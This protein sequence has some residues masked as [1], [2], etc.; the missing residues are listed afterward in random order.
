M[1]EGRNSD[2][3]H[4]LVLL[5]GSWGRHETDLNLSFRILYLENYSRRTLSDKVHR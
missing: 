5:E 3:S 4:D 2:W 1:R